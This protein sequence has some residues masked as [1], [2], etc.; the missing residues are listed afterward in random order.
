MSP[1]ADVTFA[2]LVSPATDVLLTASMI[3]AA[4]ADLA[5]PASMSP[6]VNVATSRQSTPEGSARRDEVS[7]VLRQ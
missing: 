5:F 4:A 7:S 1:T 2:A 3:P 6:A